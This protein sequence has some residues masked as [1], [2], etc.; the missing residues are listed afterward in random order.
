LN[1]YR[2][3]ASYAAD[4]SKRQLLTPNTK[5]FIPII[6][7]RMTAKL[8]TKGSRLAIV[9]NVNKNV[10]AQVNMGTGKDVNSETI[11]DAGKPLILK[12]YNDSQINLPLTP[13]SEK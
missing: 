3:R 2:S 4:M 12:W 6:N 8:I 9:L 13:W 11:A 1:N 10:D 5:T 7:A